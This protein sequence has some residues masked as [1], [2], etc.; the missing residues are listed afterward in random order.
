MVAIHSIHSYCD[1]AERHEATYYYAVFCAHLFI[2]GEP[3]CSI[4]PSLLFLAAQFD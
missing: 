2:L 4:N 1:Y 3:D